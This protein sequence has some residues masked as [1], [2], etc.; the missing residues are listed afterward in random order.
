MVDKKV[1]VPP[2]IGPDDEVQ[3]STQAHENEKR[4]VDSRPKRVSKRPNDWGLYVH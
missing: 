1:V 4:V 3:V 2:T